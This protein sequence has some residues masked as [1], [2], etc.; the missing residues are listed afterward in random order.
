MLGILLGSLALLV[1]TGSTLAFLATKDE[2]Q[3]YR[4]F[5]K[6]MTEGDAG[7]VRA[8]L[9]PD[10][11]AAVDADP[12]LESLLGSFCAIDDIAIAGVSNTADE[13]ARITGELMVESGTVAYEATMV[14]V[15]GQTKI[16]AFDFSPPCRA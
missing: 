9:H 4:D 6:R 12:E 11:V 1:V 15:D 14:S 2:R 13:G 5:A 3:L 8:M 16:A 7:A 10:L